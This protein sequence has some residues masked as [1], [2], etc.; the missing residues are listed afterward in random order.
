[1][2][3]ELVNIEHS[4]N[5]A[6]LRQPTATVSFPLTTEIKQLIAD[7]KQKVVEIDG[8][9]LAAPQVGRA[10]NLFVYVISEDAKSLRKDATEVIPVTALLN[11][12]YEPIGGP[13]EK[14]VEDWEGCFSVVSTMG[15]VPRYRR[16]KYRAQDEDGNIVQGIAKGFTARV[17]QHEIDHLHATLIIDRLEKHHTHGPIEAMRELRL[18]ELTSKQR[19]F[20]KQK[21]LSQTNASNNKKEN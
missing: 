7:M 17:L 14:K 8:V 12:T 3:L 9:G 11:A 19:D 2:S 16:I 4:E 18:K 20:I 1:M 6:V 10:L 5:K 13:A 15:K 21:Q